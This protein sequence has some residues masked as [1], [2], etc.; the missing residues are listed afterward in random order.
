MLLLK[1]SY[2]ANGSEAKRTTLVN[3]NLLKVLKCYI[4]VLLK[5]LT[6]LLN[7]TSLLYEIHF[8][9]TINVEGN[10]KCIS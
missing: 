4:S 2:V 7:S 10:F 3:L 8:Y 5:G 9:F 1:I 6:L